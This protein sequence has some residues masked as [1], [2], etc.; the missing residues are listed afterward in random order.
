M[1]TAVNQIEADLGPIHTMVY[2]AGKNFVSVFFYFKMISRHSIVQLTYNQLQH[3]HQMF[4]INVRFMS[5]GQRVKVGAECQIF[6]IV[7]CFNCGQVLQS[8]AHSTCY[9]GALTQ[10][11]SFVLL[12]LITMSA[13]KT[14]TNI[15]R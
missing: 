15:Q 5:F 2:N 13:E 11:R 14:K 3:K 10:N 7:I 9:K 6:V 8:G 4:C 1:E 12:D